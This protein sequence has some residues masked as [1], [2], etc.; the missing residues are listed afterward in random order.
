MYDKHLQFPEKRDNKHK[1]SRDV[2]LRTFEE[3]SMSDLIVNDGGVYYNSF[4]QMVF[5][6]QSRKYST[7]V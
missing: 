5:T 7:R 4:F 3:V 2:K 1:G 6:I